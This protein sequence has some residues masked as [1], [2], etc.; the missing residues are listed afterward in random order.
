MG[1]CMQV[2]VFKGKRRFRRALVSLE[3]ME[4]NVV[5]SRHFNLDSRVN[6]KSVPS[7]SVMHSLLPYSVWFG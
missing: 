4:K 1:I 2:R 6:L 7:F 3:N 5:M